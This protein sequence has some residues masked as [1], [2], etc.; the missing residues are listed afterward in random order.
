MKKFLLALLVVICF[1]GAAANAQQRTKLYDGVYIVN[2]GGGTYGIEDDSTQQCISISIA[3]DYID[4]S[5]N[6]KMYKVVCGKW[7]KRVVKA[8]INA[9]VAYG[10]TQ[11]AGTGTKIVKAA[12]TA[13]NW[14]YEDFCEYWESKL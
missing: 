4:R 7:S 2:Y 1:G 10:I 3:Q 13:A 14:I 11:T 12:G 5:N 8:G 9:A 6:Q